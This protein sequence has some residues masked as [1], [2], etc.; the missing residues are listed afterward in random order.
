MN[1]DYCVKEK[2]HFLQICWKKGTSISPQSCIFNSFSMTISELSPGIN[3]YAMTNYALYT[4]G[5]TTLPI[6]GT[7]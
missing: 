3:Q 7:L 5:N 4:L 2:I 6:K 1:Y